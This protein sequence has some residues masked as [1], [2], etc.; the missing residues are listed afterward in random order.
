MINYWDGSTH[1]TLYLVMIHALSRSTIARDASL[2]WFGSIMNR[3]ELVS[4]PS[5]SHLLQHQSL[6]VFMP[7][8]VIGKYGDQIKGC[9]RAV[10]LSLSSHPNPHSHLHQQQHHT[11]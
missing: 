8:N 3:F 5:S 11:Y 7:G 1:Y 10:Y 2:Y 9:S 4:T 6:V